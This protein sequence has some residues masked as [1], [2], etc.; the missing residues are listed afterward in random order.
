MI[1]PPPILWLTVGPH[2]FVNEQGDKLFY[3]A[4]PK[5]IFH[6]L[7]VLLILTTT[8]L[9]SMEVRGYLSVKCGLTLNI[10]LVSNT[11]IV[12]LVSSRWSHSMQS[13]FEWEE[14][15]SKSYSFLSMLYALCKMQYTPNKIHISTAYYRSNYTIHIYTVATYH[16]KGIQITINFMNVLRDVTHTIFKDYGHAWMNK[17]YSTLILRIQ[18]RSRAEI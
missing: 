9:L 10:W 6:I 17:M 13:N 14:D 8:V 12:Q 5:L 7:Y 11:Y 16:G 2:M 18:V 4:V 1:C 15:L 3:W